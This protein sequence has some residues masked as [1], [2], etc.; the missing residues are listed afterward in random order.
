MLDAW[1]RRCVA[2]SFLIVGGL[3]FGALVGGTGAANA[4]GLFEAL[5]G[6]RVI[7]EARPVVVISPGRWPSE[8]RR[9]KCPVARDFEGKARRFVAPAKPKPCVAPEVV[10]GPLRR[11]LKDETLRRGDVV[12]TAAGLMVFQGNS[13][14]THRAK[15]FVSV[16]KA[17]PMLSKKV[18][19]DLAQFEVV[20]STGVTL[21][22]LASASPPIVAQDET[23]AVR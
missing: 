8:S 18:R 6:R 23:V 22:D 20:R 12:V 15:D 19:T 13:G 21:S 16:A 14:S 7:E 2:R 17:A 11:F 4:Q 1:G 10:P 5:F 9:Q 3:A